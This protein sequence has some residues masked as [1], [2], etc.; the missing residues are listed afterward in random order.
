VGIRYLDEFGFNQPIVDEF[1][2]RY[3]DVSLR[4][5]PLTVEQKLHWHESRGKFVTDFLREL[6]EALAA[7]GKA[8][9]VI[10]D[11]KE[12]DYAQPWWGK[13]I[14]GTGLIHMDWET[15]VAEGIVDELWVQLGYV[16]DQRAV[17]DSL[18]EKTANTDVKLTVRTPTPFDA[19]WDPYVEAGVTPVAC[20]TSPVNGIE[21]VT[22]EP[23]SVAALT[24]PDWRL[25]VQALADITDGALE[26]DTA[27][28]A[29]LADD[30][31]VL[32][33][34]RA[35]HALAAL[36]ARDQVPAIE[37]ALTADP[38]SSV[39]MAAAGALVHVNGPESPARL[40]AALEGDSYFQFKQACVDAL[41][42]MKAMSLPTVTKGT[43]H[44]L[45]AVR[46]VSVRALHKL[47]R[48]GLAAE[49]YEP[50]RAVLRAP[51]EDDRVRYW[52][53]DGLVGLRL[54][55]SAQQRSQLTSDLIA[56][57]KSG[58]PP[59]VQ[60]HAAY[61]LGYMASY[62]TPETN[63]EARTCL[64]DLFREYG[65]GC[66]RSDAA[67]GWRVVGNAMLQFHE[68]GAAML[69]DLRSR[70][71]DRWLAWTAYQVVHAPLRAGVLALTDEASAIESHDKYAPEFPGVRRW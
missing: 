33:R 28:V 67:F 6:H 21:R 9:S 59:V 62:M 71:E 7:K 23:T 18:L 38:E 66:R 48:G 20:I 43:S 50:L 41:E 17:L 40:L 60:L 55:F 35:M 52:A 61:A 42:A 12:P 25:R 32:V 68:P 4:E 65:D 19:G 57:I 54:E 2:K 16:A 63:L 3:P 58:A 46:E 24:S 22:L 5:D 27:T 56:V 36:G 37:R 31:H 45:Q 70:T 14:P 26:A 53:T 51:D 64:S 47:G 39:R 69:E 1:N 11:S 10:I 34:R 15:W 8:L 49:V 30:P 44:S 29:L 13:E